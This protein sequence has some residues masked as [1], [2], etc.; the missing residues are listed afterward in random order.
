M[1]PTMRPAVVTL[2]DDLKWFNDMLH[3]TLDFD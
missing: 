2:D 1:A 3:S